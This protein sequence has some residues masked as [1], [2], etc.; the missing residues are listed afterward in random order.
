MTIF[1]PLAQFASLPFEK[2]KISSGSRLARVQSRANLP[3]D[4][5]KTIVFNCTNDA[6]KEDAADNNRNCRHTATLGL[7]SMAKLHWKATILKEWLRAF[8]AQYADLNKQCTDRCLFFDVRFILAMIRW[9]SYG[10]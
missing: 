10:S 6:E 8:P 7:S 4:Y 3:A 1:I 9:K 5:E 2:T